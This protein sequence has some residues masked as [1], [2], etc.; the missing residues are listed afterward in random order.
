M[1]CFRK[2]IIAILFGVI[3]TMFLFYHPKKLIKSSREDIIVGICADNGD[4]SSLKDGKYVGFEIDL[5]NSIGDSMK[6]KII[7]KDMQFNNLFP[8]LQS[9]D[10]DFIIA[11]VQ[12]TDRRG[13]LFSFSKEYLKHDSMKLLTTKLHSGIFNIKDL[14]SKNATFI[15]QSA[16]SYLS[17]LNENVKLGL[18]KEVVN[19]FETQQIIQ[20]NAKK[21]DKKRDLYFLYDPETIK[22][23]SDMEYAKGTCVI[24]VESNIRGY[25]IVMRKEIDSNDDKNLLDKIN[26]FIE[27]SEYKNK[28]LPELTNKY[29]KNKK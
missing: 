15:A 27:S 4:Y 28:L 23:I 24:Q 5:A 25:S 29:F 19:I 17:Y 1:C 2:K 16:S 22:Y 13:E 12:Y 9:G 10:I 3:F 26:K 7:F 20:D 18:V 14:D 21:K 11:S 6:K 8:A